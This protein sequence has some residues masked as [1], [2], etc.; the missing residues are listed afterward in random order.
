MK[1]S[2]IFST[3][4]CAL[5][6][7]ASLTSCLDNDD[8]GTAN[9]FTVQM[10]ANKNFIAVKDLQTNNWQS[11]PGSA[12][13]MLYDFKA[14]TMNMSVQNLQFAENKT[15]TFSIPQ[16]SISFDANGAYICKGNGPY[17]VSVA[18][19]PSYVTNVYSYLRLP[20]TAPSIFDLSFTI[21]DRYMVQ[22]V[23]A[24]NYF[25]GTT[26]IINTRD[27]KQFTTER[28]YYNL[29]IDQKTGKAELYAFEAQFV[30]SMPSLKCLSWAG[31]DYEL[32]DNGIVFSAANVIPNT[33]T[34]KNDGSV[35]KRTPQP[36][37]ACTD[38]LGTMSVAR[39]L[40]FTYNCTAMG[41]AS[42]FGTPM[43][44]YKN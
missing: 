12:A 22:M 14:G 28:T 23:P 34:F 16:L 29:E 39:N 10:L 19:A 20:A 33:V 8:K 40:T 30:E 36:A 21:D 6:G 15:A 5:I 27:D 9:S 41:K 3:A 37:Y 4:V 24:I 26:R 17:T 32:T 31:L 38:V 44:E 18:G 2:A 13:T 25:A 11:Y 43:V 7:A 35:D 1:K 42:F